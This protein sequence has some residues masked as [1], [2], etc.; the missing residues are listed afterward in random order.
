MLGAMK[1]RTMWTRCAPA[2]AG[3]L[4][5]L[6]AAAGAAVRMEGET[7]LDYYVAEVD[8]EGFEF[9]EAE[10]YVERVVNDGAGGSGP[11][12]VSGWLT[13]D[14]TPAGEGTEAGYLPFG[15]LPGA[16]SYGPVWDVVEADD[17]APGE[18]YT[19]LLL[20]KDAYPGTFEDAAALSPRLLWRGGLEA[21]GPLD[22][23][24]YPGGAD[25]TVDFAELRNNRL[26]ERYTNDILLTLYATYGYGPASDGFVLCQRRVPGLYAGDGR[27]APGFDCAID[28]I[29]DG[30]YTLHLEVAEVGG[31]GG[32]STLSGPDVRF[33]DGRMDDGSCC[34][35][36][37]VYVAGGLDSAAIGVLAL[38]LL[39]QL[40]RRQLARR[41]AWFTS[42]RISAG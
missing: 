7:T 25:V 27:Y 18:Y 41:S 9:T 12:S 17:A 1:T 35:G 31:R 28:P 39:V 13:P 37:P 20:Q 2:L 24:P 14:A 26:D 34:G 40:R 6:S 33:Y 15:S 19:H 3:S 32:A 11:L 38:G 10:I 16:S 8:A 23:I 4:M 22:I 5:V 42:S 36:D 30:E 29:P 21:L